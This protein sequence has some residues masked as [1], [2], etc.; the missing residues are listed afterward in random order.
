MTGNYIYDSKLNSHGVVGKVSWNALIHGSLDY[1]SLWVNKNPI[2]YPRA[3]VGIG[4]SYVTVGYRY[5]FVHHIEQVVINPHQFSIGINIAK[6]RN[7][8][9][10]FD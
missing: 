6:I 1:V 9:I 5:S 8:A 4:L 10:E 7:G 3:S 2:W